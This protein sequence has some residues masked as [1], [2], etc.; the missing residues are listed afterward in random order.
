MVLLSIFIIIIMVKKALLV[1][2]FDA[3]W[4]AGLESYPQHEL[5]K[6][7]MTGYGGMVT[8]F[9]KGGLEN[10]QQFFKASKVRGLRSPLILVALWSKGNQNLEERT[11]SFTSFP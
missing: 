2:L 11:E 1:S 5:A 7:Q 4:T 8:F 10:A 3:I 9:I 6:K